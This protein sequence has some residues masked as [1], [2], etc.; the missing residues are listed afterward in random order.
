MLVLPT[1]I[2]HKV[3]AL[4]RKCPG[5]LPLARR[6]RA[7]SVAIIMYHGVAAWPLP[8]FNWCQLPL[9]EFEQQL[10]FLQSQ[11]TVLPL[12]EVIERMVRRA[13]LPRHTAVLTFDDGFRN[14]LTTAYPVLERYQMPATVFLVTGFIGTGQP[15]WPD[16]LYHAAATTRKNEVV[17]DDLRRALATPEQRASAYRALAARL[18]AL[19]AERKD[20]ALVELHRQLDVPAQVPADSPLATLDWPEVE[21]LQRGGLIDF[22]SHTHTHPI[23]ARCTPAVQAE[24]LR[25]SRDVLRERLGRADLFAYPNGTR[26]DYTADTKRFLIELGYSCGLGTEPG[27]NGPTADRYALRRV[28][29][30]ADTDLASFELHMVGL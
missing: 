15:A 12:R 9:A 19:P 17:L 6:T 20:A 14:V 26:T 7:G 16:R 10:D 30:G 28:N 2:P 21:Q 22:G 4:G 8:V 25:C 29:V 18:K 27:L 3:L 5:F 23:L 13:P 11:Y 24:E 1:R